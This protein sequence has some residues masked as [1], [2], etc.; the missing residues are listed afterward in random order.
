MAQSA[1]TATFC[2]RKMETE[3]ANI[4]AGVYPQFVETETM[5]TLRALQDTTAVS[6]VTVEEL[7]D[8]RPQA[9]TNTEWRVRFPQLDYSGA[10]TT[11][12][13]TCAR[14]TGAPS[15]IPELYDRATVDLVVNTEFSIDA[16]SFK[17]DDCI[18][19]MRELANELFTAYRKLKKG[20]NDQLI[21]RVVASAGNYFTPAG[22]TPVNSATNPQP[23]NLFT[24][25]SP[26]QPQPLGL[27]HLK[28][29]YD[30]FGVGASPI[31]VLGGGY[32]WSTY[33]YA[34]KLFD[35]NENGFNALKGLN[36]NPYVDY[37]IDEIAAD[38][39]EHAYS[40][41]AGA[42]HLLEW[43]EFNNELIANVPNVAPFYRP[44][45][46]SG[47][48]VRQRIDLAQ[49]IP[50]EARS[51]NAPF[52]VDMEVR[53]DE[54]CNVVNYFFQKFF[55]IWTIPQAAFSTA[56]NQAHNYI[57]HWTIGGNNETFA[58]LPR[59]VTSP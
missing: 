57:L 40:W 54:N 39:T 51:D 44:T 58:T 36:I 53:L 6:P 34:G 37:R 24:A 52:W 42:I 22:G 30:R 26:T 10:G 21:P 35:Q 32:S 50:S 55:D 23:I 47:T 45:Q 31:T 46:S 17:D 27:A 48:L 13:D 5:D 16:R 19:P 11:A 12:I 29:Q 56:K 3:L 1:T 28:H 2:C 8:E 49:M 14:T 15:R 33:D 38:S 59:T 4:A 25:Q 41:V 20:V 9:A 43:Y 7:T 18:D